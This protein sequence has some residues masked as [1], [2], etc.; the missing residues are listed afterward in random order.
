MSNTNINIKIDLAVY[1]DVDS[2]ISAVYSFVNAV[3]LYVDS[4]IV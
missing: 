2:I 1:K 4:A 3:Y